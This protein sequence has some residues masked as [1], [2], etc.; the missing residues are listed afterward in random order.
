MK[1]NDLLTVLRSIAPESLAESWDKVGLHVESTAR[2]KRAMLCIDLTQ[3]VM[4]EAIEKKVNLIVAYHPPIF[5][6]LTALTRSDYKQNIILLA[7]RNN[8]AIYSPH[9]ALDAASTGVNQFLAEGIAGDDAVFIRP[10][11]PH[12]NRAEQYKLVT[13]APEASVHAIRE[14]L[15][16]AGAGNIGNYSECSF[17]SRGHG[18][19]K[20]NESTNPAIGQATEFESVAEMRVEMVLP[21]NKLVAVVTALRDIHPYEEPAFDVYPMIAGPT[22]KSGDMTGQGRVVELAKPISLKTLVTRIKAILKLDYLE[23]APAEGST[24]AKKNIQRIGLCAGAGQSLIEEARAAV[25]QDAGEG[26]GLDVFFTGEMRHHDTL[27]AVCS[28]LAVILAGHTRTERPFLADYRKQIKAQTR[29]MG[30]G[31]VEWVISKA[32]RSPGE[33]V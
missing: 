28:G 30:R 8:I 17:T 18:T 26:E 4:Q 13:F 23:V 1:L 16:E 31:D 32:D 3:S 10:I 25:K 15:S 19:F 5:A 29:E 21:K 27:A 9:T 11:R 2:I 6:P 12:D 20:G 7:A 14:S 22:S 33:V 24:M